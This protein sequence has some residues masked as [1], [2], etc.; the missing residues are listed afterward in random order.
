MFLG[1]LRCPVAPCSAA[2]RSSIKTAGAAE[3]VR[4]VGAG[5]IR[6]KATV[7]AK[8]LPAEP[9]QVNEIPGPRRWPVVACMPYILTHKEYEKTRMHKL[10]DVC[11]REFGPI[12]R[13]DMPGQA[14]TVFISEPD[15]I[16]H[17]LKST[18]KNQQRDLFSSLKYVRDTHEFFKK[19]KSGIMSEQ[20]DEWWRVRRR[21]QPY[22]AKPKNVELYLPQMDQVILDFTESWASL[23]NEINELPDDFDQELYCWALETLGLVVFNKRLGYLEG[24]TEVKTIVEMAR[25]IFSYVQDLEVSSPQWWRLVTTPKLRD[26]RKTHDTLLCFVQSS[27]AEVEA[28]LDARGPE[29]EVDGLTLVE[30]LLLDPE[31]SREDA[32][33]YLMDLLTA[34]IDAVAT[35]AAFVLTILAQHPEKQQK[36]HEELDAVLGDGRQPL[37][38]QHIAKLRYTKACVKEVLRISSPAPLT[39]RQLVEDTVICGYLV[40]KG[41]NVTLL[42]RPAGMKEQYFARAAEFVPERWLRGQPLGPINPYSSM[43]FSLGVR[44]CVGRRFA[45]QQ[46]YTLLARLLHKYRVEWH[47]GPLNP[48]MVFTLIPDKPLRLKMIERKV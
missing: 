6:C 29:A 33:A 22:T 7:A 12:F 14:P 26:L 36:V 46:T 13:L 17:V 30:M 24:N 5:N 45:E 38:P 32:H 41:F 19:D 15:D 48:I 25:A 44:S 34:G 27:V 23:R 8:A 2:L 35:K 9:L 21:V 31:L 43:P 10:W 39:S 28:E 18:A 20:G 40:P 4:V 47:Y 3:V 42:L 37:T 11:V 1:L 16:E